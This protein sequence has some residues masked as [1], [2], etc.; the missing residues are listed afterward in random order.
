MKYT[1]NYNV[2]MVSAVIEKK[3]WKKKTIYNIICIYTHT[4]LN[5]NHNRRKKNSNN[6]SHARKE[7]APKEK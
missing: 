5:D 1:M 6:N 7:T 3:K 4:M 2:G